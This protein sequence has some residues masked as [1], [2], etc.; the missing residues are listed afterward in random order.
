M[1]KAGLSKVIL[2]L[3]ILST[4]FLAGC[5][6]DTSDKKDTPN[7]KVEQNSEDKGNQDN[8]SSASGTY[9]F[10]GNGVELCVDM[11][12]A[13]VSGKLGEPNSFFEEPSCA[14][15]GIAKIYTY[16]G[17]EIYTY[18]DG[19]RDLIQ[20]ISLKDDSVA[21]P[22]GIDLSKTKD[23][24][25]SAYG[26]DYEQKGNSLVYTKGNGKLVFILDGDYITSIEYDS[27]VFN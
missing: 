15:E 14:A 4:C 26:S 27:S 24:I 16:S 23:D 9:V 1:K 12:M 2:G 3:C 10:V 8:N 25:I 20:Y 21:T 13:T 19:D 22:E 6:S 5:G 11:D 18:P 17:F 7:N